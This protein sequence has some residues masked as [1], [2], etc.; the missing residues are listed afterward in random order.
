M[1]ELWKRETQE[2]KQQLQ[3]EALPKFCKRCK[4]ESQALKIQQRK[5]MKQNKKMLNLKKNKFS[6]KNFWKSGTIWK[7]KI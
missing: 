6:H 7:Y 3:R 4:R 2:F 5:W 1:R